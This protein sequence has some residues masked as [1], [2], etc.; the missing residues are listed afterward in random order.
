[1]H[2]DEYSV[3]Q[4]TMLAQVFFNFPNLVESIGVEELIMERV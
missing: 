2:L 3:S 1:M 4:L